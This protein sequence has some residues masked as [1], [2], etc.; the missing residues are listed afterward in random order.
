MQLKSS[1]RT[2]SYRLKRE[3]TRTALLTAARSLFGAVGRRS[4]T[5]DALVEKAG[6]AKGTFYLYFNDLTELD[7]AVGKELLIELDSSCRT[8]RVDVPD[9]L[10][11][12]ATA[13]A[14]LLNTI[15]LDPERARL[16]VRASIT[17]PITDLAI[18]GK[19]SAELAEAR[20]ADRL[21]PQD[22][23]IA[24]DVVFGICLQMVRAIGDGRLADGGVE[25]ATAAMLVAIGITSSE[26]ADVAA[27]AVRE[28]PGERCRIMA[29]VD[30][31]AHAQH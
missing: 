10:I 12:L 1:A 11:R 24:A 3:Q 19:L 8:S 29:K 13:F 14:L 20:A 27:Q 4:V 23:D 31:T 30:G 15:A 5:V 17:L 7:E 25:R 2:E 6:V 22:M 18:R 16:L 26:A 28:G 9:P 21:P